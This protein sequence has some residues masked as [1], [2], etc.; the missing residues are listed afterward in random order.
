MADFHALTISGVT[1]P[2]PPGWSPP[3]PGWYPDPYG[4]PCQRWWDGQQ[5]T[6]YTAATPPDAGRSRGLVI[7]IPTVVLVA[8]VVVGY[9]WFHDSTYQNCLVKPGLFDW[10][11]QCL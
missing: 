6:G 1:T 4:H 10:P 2:T 5:W 9:I 7:S 11:S 8:I 3:D